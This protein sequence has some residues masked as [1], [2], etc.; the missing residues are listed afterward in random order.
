MVSKSI[1]NI[2]ERLDKLHAAMAPLMAVAQRLERIEAKLDQL[3]AAQK[4]AEMPR[5]QAPT[6]APDKRG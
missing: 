3:L 1:T 5:V 4:P 2:L 6:R